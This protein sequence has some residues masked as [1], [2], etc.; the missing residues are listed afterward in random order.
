MFGVL[1]MYK[2]FSDLKMSLVNEWMYWLIDGKGNI[3]GGKLFLMLLDV[4]DE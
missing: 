2:W 3:N 4:E 1:I